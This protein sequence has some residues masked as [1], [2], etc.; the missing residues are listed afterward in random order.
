ME[1]TSGKHFFASGRVQGVFYRKFCSDQARKLGLK[2]WAKNLKDGRVEVKA[3]G[4]SDALTLYAKKLQS[5][6]I[7]SKVSHL[8]EQ[9]IPFEQYE[10]FDVF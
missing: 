1:K 5:G 10:G 2:G 8:S 4:N 9:D 6:P 7:F 3:F